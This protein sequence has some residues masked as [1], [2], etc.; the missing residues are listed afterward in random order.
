[1]KNFFLVI[2]KEKIYAYI[3][4]ILTILTLFFVSDMINSEFKETEPVSSNV[5]ELENE[6]NNNS[7][8]NFT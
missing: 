4:S 3:V 1:M 2:N 8:N 6:I 5:I 7:I